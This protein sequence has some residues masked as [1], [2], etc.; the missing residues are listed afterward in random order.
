V[1]FLAAGTIIHGGGKVQGLTTG[2][3]IWLSGA[4]GVACGSG[5][6][7]IAT[8]GTAMALIIIVLLRRFE[9]HVLDTKEKRD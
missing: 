3:G 9:R 8:M 7:M 5:F 2:A 1:S 6:Y 4:V